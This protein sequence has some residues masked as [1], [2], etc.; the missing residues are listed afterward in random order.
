MAMKT[1]GAESATPTQ[2]RRCMLLSS[3]LSASAVGVFGS[4]AMPQIGQLPGASRTICGCIGHVHSTLLA[5]GVAET[6]RG[7]VGWASGTLASALR[8]R[9]GSCLNRGGVAETSRG[10][11]GWASGTLASAL[12]YRRG[13]CLNRSRQLWLQNK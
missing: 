4:S 13:S 5:G 11:V 9:R 8:Y 2:N 10:G 1:S 12:R 6:S 3:G 7:G